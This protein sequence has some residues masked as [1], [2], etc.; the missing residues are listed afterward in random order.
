MCAADARS[1]LD[2]LGYDLVALVG[3]S[4]GGSVAFACLRAFPER[5]SALVLADTRATPDDDAGRQAREATARL[6]EERGPVALFDR[7][8]ERL[9]GA[10]TRRE[11]PE[12]VDRGHALAAENPAAGVAA[13]ARGM[14]LRADSS[15][16]L[17]LIECPTLVVVGEQ[18]VITPVADARA[19]FERIPRARLDVLT[20]A[21]HLSNMDQPAQFNASLVDFLRHQH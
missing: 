5:I 12:V 13:A 18:D 11:H 3:L 7:D 17:P 6:A 16:L 2:K 15:D 8:A 20:D 14:A 10:W 4:M 19:M 21:G 1:L 9:F